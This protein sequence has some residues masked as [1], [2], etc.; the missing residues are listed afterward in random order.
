MKGFRYTKSLGT[1]VG[2][3]TILGSCGFG[4]LEFIGLGLSKALNS[5][6]ILLHSF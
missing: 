5:G 6:K 3:L 4:F 2:V 1:I